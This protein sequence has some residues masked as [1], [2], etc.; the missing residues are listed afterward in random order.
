MITLGDRL[1]RTWGR[2]PSYAEIENWLTDQGFTRSEKGWYC[3]G[4]KADCLQP[5]EIITMVWLE[6]TDGV[7]FIDPP[8]P[9]TTRSQS[10]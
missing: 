9:P 8:S 2:V 6:T 1:A 7:T 4:E 5:N 3:D 10:A